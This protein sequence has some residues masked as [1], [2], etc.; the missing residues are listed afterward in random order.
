MHETDED[1]DIEYFKELAGQA[2][3]AAEKEADQKAEEDIAY[4]K[5]RL[6][7]D[8]GIC[9]MCGKLFSKHGEDEV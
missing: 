2:D 9:P 1:Q 5:E 8:D 3:A 6:R 4:L 7:E